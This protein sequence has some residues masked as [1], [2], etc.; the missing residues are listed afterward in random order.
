MSAMSAG[1]SVVMQRRHRGNVGRFLGQRGPGLTRIRLDT[2][3]Q[4]LAGAYDARSKNR[5]FILTLDTTSVSQQG[6]HAENTFSTG[7]RRRRPAQGR[8]YSQKKH[9]RHSCHGHVFGMLTTPHG[10]RLPY[11]LPYYTKEY[12]RQRGLKHRTQAD[13][14]AEIIR[15]VP[16]PAKGEL[17][18]LGDTAFESRQVRAACEQREATWIF[19][20]NP[21][22]VLAGRKPRPKVS[23][24]LRQL[25]GERFV[26]IRLQLSDDFAPYRR[27]A[28]C[29]LKSNKA[30]TFYV[31]Q[32]R[33]RVHNVGDVQLV[34]SVSQKPAPGK[35][36]P[37]SQVKTLLTDS[38]QLSA[39]EIVALYALRWQ[40]EL[41]FKELKSVLGMHQYRFR[42]FH[43]IVAWIEA[44]LIT[45]LYLEWVRLERLKTRT[46]PARE[47]AWWTAQRAFGL[48]TS[49]RQRVEENELHVIRKWT[50]T[51][52]GQRKLRAALRAAVTTEYRHAA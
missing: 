52:W 10:V 47:R 39:R 21:E 5:R 50:R 35:S 20:A 32:E 46:L 11:Y 19:P 2:A 23:S 1:S 49:V 15:R 27:A 30:R 34:F 43:R 16:L 7:N 37:R 14:A 45:L 51:R 3:R 9:A 36:V 4:L 44:C 33:R 22:R 31:H 29:R 42:Q 48:A 40:I 24:L 13:L 6:Q 26:P 38:L 25:T 28:R 8:R 41:L 17:I 18:V 12:C